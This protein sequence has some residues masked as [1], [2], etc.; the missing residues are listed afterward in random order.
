MTNFQLIHYY[1][2]DA[3]TVFIDA[4]WD[5]RMQPVKLDEMIK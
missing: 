1:D 3:D 5:M 2:A 4:I